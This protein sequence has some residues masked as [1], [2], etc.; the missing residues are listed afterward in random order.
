MTFIAILK[1]PSV[2][3]DEDNAAEV[4]KARGHTELPQDVEL[5]LI[6]DQ[7]PVTPVPL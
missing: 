3:G 6:T 4:Y 5:E 2:D 7:T 1:E